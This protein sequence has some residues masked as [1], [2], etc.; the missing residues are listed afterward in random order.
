MTHRT[1]FGYLSQEMG[2][3]ETALRVCDYFSAV[4]GFY[5]TA[6]GDLNQAAHRLALPSGFFFS[7]QEVGTL[8][9]GERVKLQLLKILIEK[10]DV[11]L[12]DEPSND[13][14]IET[15]KWL[16]GFINTCPMPVLY[17]SHD[18]T[19]IETPRTPPSNTKGTPETRSRCTAAKCR[20]GRSIS[21]EQLA[22][23]QNARKEQSECR[24]S[25]SA[26]ENSAK[27]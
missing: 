24:Q 16:E 23:E 20:T 11:L 15:L 25:S 10:P 7:E 2:D 17:V 14:D 21:A 4:T 6:P 19:L 18:E 13:V 8:S 22:S 1:R 27:G 12:L 3:E 9:G 5:D 26:S